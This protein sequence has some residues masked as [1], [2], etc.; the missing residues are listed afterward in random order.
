[1]DRK[2]V[3]KLGSA[4]LANNVHSRIWEG[5]MAPF[6]ALPAQAF[7]PIA[8]APTVRS[9]LRV[10]CQAA[11]AA[12]VDEPAVLATPFWN[13]SYYPTGADVSQYKK[14]F[15]VIDAKDQTLGRLATLAATYIRGKHAST[16]SPSMDMGAYVIV[17]NA[18][19]VKVTGRK[20]DNKVYF[21]HVNGRPGS[22]TFESFKSLQ[23]RLPERIIEHAVHGML[24]K[25]RL[26]RRIRLHLIVYKGPKHD[27]DSFLPIDITSSINAK[28]SAM[29]SS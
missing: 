6:Q 21:S 8:R 1:M 7:R 23:K 4:M 22:S 28:T 18:E 25:G 24:P 11:A 17:I 2:G 27:F 26:G 10:K 13:K 15:Y 3:G 12:A 16:Y 14:R 29:P 20:F 19:K 5:R 9:A